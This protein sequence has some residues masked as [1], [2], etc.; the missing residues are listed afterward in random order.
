M[1]WVVAATCECNL[2]LVF[3]RPLVGQE[4]GRYM[5]VQSE[6]AEMVDVYTSILCGA[7]EVIETV[8]TD[9][10]AQPCTA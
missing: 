6:F 7:F 1:Q 9:E 10:L 8:Y 2:K 5:F 3:E 4:T